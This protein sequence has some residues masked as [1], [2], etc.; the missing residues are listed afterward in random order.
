M[1]A[2]AVAEKGHSECNKGFGALDNSDGECVEPSWFRD[3]NLSNKGETPI[4]V[5]H[6]Q[7]GVLD[8]ALILV[9]EDNADTG[10]LIR[11][12]LE[13]CRATVMM[14]TNGFD[15]LSLFRRRR[16]SLIISDISMPL[17]DGYELL[18]RV[19]QLDSQD[20]ANT[21]AIAITAYCDPTK[22]ERAKKVGFMR[23]LTKPLMPNDL[24]DTIREVLRRV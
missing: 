17:M 24:L 4:Q 14:A 20:G 11:I 7:S 2:L 13:R 6:A 23:L 9:A 16:P 8:G 22:Q 18:D 15:A 21:P 19:R 10:L 12:Q 3:A 5:T 1:D